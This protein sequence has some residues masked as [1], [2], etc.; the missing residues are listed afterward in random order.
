MLKY[1]KNQI[2]YIMVKSKV[3]GNHK[4]LLFVLSLK[5]WDKYELSSDY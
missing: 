1:A 3:A 4:M 5:T 2:T